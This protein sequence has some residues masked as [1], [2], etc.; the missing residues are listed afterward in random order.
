MSQYKTHQKALIN[1]ISASSVDLL[2]FL[3]QFLK[4]NRIHNSNELLQEFE[5]TLI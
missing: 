4:L 1:V 5:D 2:S 3:S